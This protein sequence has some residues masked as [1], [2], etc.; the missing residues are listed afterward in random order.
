MLLSVCDIDNELIRTVDIRNR[1]SITT[2]LWIDEYKYC[3]QTE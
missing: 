1:V 2:Q 3:R